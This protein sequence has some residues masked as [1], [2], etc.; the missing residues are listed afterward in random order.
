LSLYSERELQ[1]SFVVIEP[2]RHRIR[3][4]SPGTGP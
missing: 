2:G 3:K 1:D 4:L